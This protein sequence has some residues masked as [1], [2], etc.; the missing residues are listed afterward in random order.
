VI[1]HQQG[2]SVWMEEWRLRLEVA[3]QQEVE[4]PAVGLVEVEALVGRAHVDSRPQMLAGVHTGSERHLQEAHM[5]WL[6]AVACYQPEEVE[7]P[8]TA[9]LAERTEEL[10]QVHI[11]SMVEVQCMATDREGSSSVVEG[12]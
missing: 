8:G 4:I 7:G 1:D 10:E 2:A 5:G 12:G 9:E 6:V 11:G 3:G